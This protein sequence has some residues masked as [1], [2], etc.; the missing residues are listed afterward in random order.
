[1]QMVIPSPCSRVPSIAHGFQ[2]GVIRVHPDLSTRVVIFQ[3]HC[4]AP[5]CTV[6][7]LQNECVFT[8]PDMEI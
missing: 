2:T 5:E 6:C 8:A 3:C 7:N 1:M 4:N